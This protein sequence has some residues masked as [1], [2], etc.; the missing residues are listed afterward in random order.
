MTERTRRL[1]AAVRGH[2]H[3]WRVLF[4]SVRICHLALI[5]RRV[6]KTWHHFASVC[7]HV[8][9]FMCVRPGL[10][11]VCVCVREKGDS[12]LVPDGQPP[13]PHQLKPV[14]QAKVTAAGTTQ[15]ICT[16]CRREQKEI[17]CNKPKPAEQSGNQIYRSNKCFMCPFTGTGFSS[18]SVA[19]L[20]SHH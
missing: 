15:T 17:T 3:E 9:V 10:C 16:F 7:M 19:I 6:C 11:V 18:L 20:L 14:S 13:S 8:C 4:R 1:C 5:C 2:F 12:L